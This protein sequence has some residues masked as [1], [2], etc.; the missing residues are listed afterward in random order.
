MF[1]VV[2][3]T[4]TNCCILV[5][6]AVVVVYVDCNDMYGDVVVANTDYAHIIVEGY[7]VDGGCHI[8][9]VVIAASIIVCCYVANNVV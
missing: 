6:F 9:A 3:M 2:A 8:I 7:D 5:C 1:V 4:V